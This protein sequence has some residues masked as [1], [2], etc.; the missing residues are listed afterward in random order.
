M[1]LGRYGLIYNNSLVFKFE[2]NMSGIPSRLLQNQSS[3][4]VEYSFFGGGWR[5]C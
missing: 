5:A 3:F 1:L 4:A 2:S